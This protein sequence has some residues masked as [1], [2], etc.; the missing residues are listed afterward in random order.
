MNFVKSYCKVHM[1]REVPTS[2]WVEQ[3]KQ[4]IGKTPEEQD[5]MREQWAKEIEAMY[6]LKE[7][8]RTGK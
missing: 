2:V 3:A 4:L 5:A 7:K 1:E 6:P 8:Y